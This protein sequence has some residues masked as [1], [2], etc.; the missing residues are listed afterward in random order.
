MP[1]ADLHC[2]LLVAGNVWRVSSLP[3][4]LIAWEM[5]YSETFKIFE[6]TVP[7]PPICLCIS[8]FNTSITSHLIYG[9]W[10]QTPLKSIKTKL[11]NIFGPWITSPLLW[12][13]FN[14]C[15]QSTHTHTQT[16]TYIRQSIS[17]WGRPFF[18]KRVFN[19]R[20]KGPTK[21]LKDHFI[22]NAVVLKLYQVMG[23]SPLDRWE[24]DSM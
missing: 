4:H 6:F 9:S 21:R 20:G 14:L 11:I 7:Q 19:S 8:V 23:S 24:T 15:T 18:S 12:R 1:S 10:K 13:P 22:E 3:E 17:H 16:N 2:G 5:A